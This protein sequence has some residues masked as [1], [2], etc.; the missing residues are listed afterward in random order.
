MN[1]RATR[2]NFK[3]WQPRFSIAGIMLIMIIFSVMA[4]SASY[5]YKAASGS[6]HFHFIAILFTFVAPVFL[7][8]VISAAYWFLKRKR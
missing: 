4:A 1:D 3:P 5:M 8:M 6:K 2:K 7:M